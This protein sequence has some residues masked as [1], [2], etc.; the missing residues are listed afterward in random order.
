M[1]DLKRR[2]A[3]PESPEALAAEKNAIYLEL[4]RDARAFPEMERF[5]RR[6]RARRIP[7]AAAS[8]SSPHVLRRVLDAAG[9]T[10]QL[11]AIVS[12][13]EVPRGKPAP[14]VFVEAARRLGVP[15]QACVA[16]EDSRPG[17]EAACRAFMR[18]IAVPYLVEEPLPDGFLMAD[19]LFERGMSAFD[20]ER[21]WAWL[22]PLLAEGL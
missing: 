5:L 7:V 1:A 10:S 8:G 16:V 21:A 2:F 6:V 15:A 11:D 13:E 22:E 3:L 18:C 4:A 9:V 12:A 14:D 20:A 19:L 17:V